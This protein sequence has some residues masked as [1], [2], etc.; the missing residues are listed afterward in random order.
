MDQQKKKNSKRSP[1]LFQEVLY[2]LIKIAVI[3]AAAAAL[4][5]FIFGALRYNS[6]NMAPAVKEGDLVLFY[7]LDKDYIASENLVMKY[8][9]EWMVQRVVAVSGDTVDISGDGLLI[10]GALQQESYVYTDT[11]RFVS[12]VD[13][14]LT[15]GEGEVFVLSDNRENATDSRIFGVVRVQDTYGTVAAIFRRRNL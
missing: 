1:T 14:P 12:D 5:T 9:G 11:E 13:F 3:L 8:N 10:N 6:A 7:R 4:F 2:L 15:V